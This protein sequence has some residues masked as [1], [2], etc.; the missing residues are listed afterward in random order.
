M[1]HDILE[2]VVSMDKQIHRNTLEIVHRDKFGRLKSRDFIGFDDDLITNVGLAQAAGL[3]N[4]VVTSH[5]TYLAIGIGTTAAAVT[6][7]ALE[8]EIATGGGARAGATASRVTTTITND[9]MQ[10]VY[11][12]TF[13]ASFAVTEMGVFDAASAGNMYCRQVFTAKNVESGDTLQLTVKA[14]M[15]RAA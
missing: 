12:W 6:D 13:T 9:T 11:T 14:Q 7:T 10:L 8:S 5:F 2:K 3:L 15:S 4:N 1:W